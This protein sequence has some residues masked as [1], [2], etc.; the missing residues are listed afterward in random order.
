MDILEFHDLT[1]INTNEVI[2]IGV[3]DKIWIV[4]G[5]TVTKF[6]LVEEVCF[7]K[8]SQCSVNSCTGSSGTS[9]TESVK[10]FVRRKVFVGVEDDSE[11]FVPLRSLSQTFLPDEIVQFV[12]NALGHVSFI[13][14]NLD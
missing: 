2:V 7:H 13:L 5:L 9:I 6:D 1:A 4:G 3:I 12:V 10:K 8:Q 14:R 11:D